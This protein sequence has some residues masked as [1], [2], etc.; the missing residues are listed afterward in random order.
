MSTTILSGRAICAPMGDAGKP[1]AHRAQA[2]GRD[3]T[4]SGASPVVD[5][6]RPHL[7]LAHLGADDG[8]AP[9]DLPDLL[10]GELGL[11]GGQLQ[12]P[13]RGDR[14]RA[15]A[16][17]QPLGR[18]GRARSCDTADF[19]RGWHGSQLQSCGPAKQWESRGNHARRR[20][21]AAPRAGSRTGNR[22]R[23]AC[24]RLPSVKCR[25]QNGDD[26]PRGNGR[27]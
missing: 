3:Q 13:V 1:K 8:L 23:R 16:P 22:P 19:R 15:G 27:R 2:A 11:R 12:G 5:P 6:R 26:R 9:G 18:S 17:G 4:A 25:I 24:S 10:H 7:V 14:A 20:G 21:R